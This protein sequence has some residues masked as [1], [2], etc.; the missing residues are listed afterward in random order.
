VTDQ[1]VDPDTLPI[2]DPDKKA[3]GGIV[4]AS[5]GALIQAQSQG[6]DTVPAM[7][8][9][10]EFVMNR[11][12][13]SQNRPMLESMNSG[14]FNSGGL[15]RYMASGGYIQPQR[16]EGGST[17]P[18]R[19]T[20]MLS[21]PGGVNNNVG[22]QVE[23][24]RPSWLDEVQAVFMR[25]AESVGNA[26][27]SEVAVTNT[28]THQHNGSIG[29]DSQTVGRAVAM[30]SQQGQNYADQR[31]GDVQ[32]ELQNQTDGGISFKASKIA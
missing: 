13:T 26:M 1:S 32:S 15:V 12:A 7:L 11:L 20:Q 30:G 21:S 3:R 16:L 9:P 31:V 19:Q 2:V 6:S 27:P 25:A 23:A 10:G 29:L 17:D 24:P 4:Y 5:N 18:V 14:Q 28:H 8:T 22:S